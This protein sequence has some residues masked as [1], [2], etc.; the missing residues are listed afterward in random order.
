MNAPRLLPATALATLA[1]A[2]TGC[3]G[4]TNP[5]DKHAAATATS[6]TS[7]PPAAPGA[8]SGSAP[9]LAPAATADAAI[10]RF[11]TKF[12]NW[13]FDH[14][15]AVKTALVAQASGPLAAQLRRDA[16]QALSEVSRR[17][18]NQASQ[19]TV[20]VVDDSAHPGQYIVVTHETAKLGDT[21]AQSGYFVYRATAARS[22]NTYKLTS[23]EAVS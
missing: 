3:G 4:L 20:Q 19:G 5:Y 10:R 17:V 6:T 18:S 1:L 9:V 11:A 13:R 8:S 15:P 2:A 7:A 12:I 14:L 21:D 23:F 16:K 22:G